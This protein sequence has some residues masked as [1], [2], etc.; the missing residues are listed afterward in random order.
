MPIVAKKVGAC[1]MLI[2]TRVIIAAEY[3]A[4]NDRNVRAALQSIAKVKKEHDKKL[5]HMCAS[6]D[7][8]AAKVDA[9][10]GKAPIVS[11][12]VSS[13]V[14]PDMPIVLASDLPL[15]IAP[16]SPM[17]AKE[18]C[19]A[20]GLVIGRTVATNHPTHIRGE[21][22]IDTSPAAMRTAEVANMRAATM[23]AAKEQ[24]TAPIARDFAA[25]EA[26]REANEEREYQR[27]LLRVAFLKSK[28][29]AE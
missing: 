27:K 7:R 12:V 15:P 14:S 20:R 1:G 23:R 26:Q 22:A 10:I 2:A 21:D 8:L 4:T 6:R 18:S 13:D 9:A 24:N 25:F 3:A 16:D 19:Y 5:V 29:G 11:P 28:L 17:I